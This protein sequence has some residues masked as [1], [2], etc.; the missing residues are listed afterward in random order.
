MPMRSTAPLGSLERTTAAIMAED[1]ADDV[2]R[3][4]RDRMAHQERGVRAELVAHRIEHPARII[5]FL[6][7]PELEAIVG[8]GQRRRDRRGHAADRRAQRLGAIV[9][10]DRVAPLLGPD[11]AARVGAQMRRCSEIFAHHISPEEEPRRLAAKGEWRILPPQ[12]KQDFCGRLGD[13]VAVEAVGSVEVGEAPGLAEFVDPE[14][15]DA[16]AEDPAEPG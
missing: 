11:H 6:G 3:L 5:E 4:Q 12:R 1:L 7:E 2:D 14:R 15:G 9:R 16:L 10:L 13:R 8:R